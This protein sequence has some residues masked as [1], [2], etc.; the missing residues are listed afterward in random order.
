[1]LDRN[2]QGIQS[3]ILFSEFAVTCDP[4]GVAACPEVESCISLR[5]I[6]REPDAFVNLRQCIRCSLSRRGQSKKPATNVFV[7]LNPFF[8][9]EGKTNLF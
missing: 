1:M 3:E 6:A 4:F 7:Y 9:W 8:D 5:G 2:A